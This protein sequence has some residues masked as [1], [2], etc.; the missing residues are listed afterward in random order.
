MNRAATDPPP[1]NM[2]VDCA[3]G[4]TT[5]VPLTP[6][7]I[8]AQQAAASQAAAQQQAAATARAQLVATVAASPDPAVQALAKLVGII[9]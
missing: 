8:A 6:D 1:D 2:T 9:S 4:D 3:T 5:C 7:Q